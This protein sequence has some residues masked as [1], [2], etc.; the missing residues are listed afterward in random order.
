MS[1]SLDTEEQK[2]FQQD[3]IIHHADSCA[4]GFDISKR[5]QRTFGA[6]LLHSDGGC[7]DDPWCKLW[8]R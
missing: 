1:G 4:P 5:I 2:D 3:N 6:S 8:L 7:Y